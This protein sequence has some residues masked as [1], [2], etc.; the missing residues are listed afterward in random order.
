M[1]PNDFL[2]ENKHSPKTIEETILPKGIKKDF[3]KEI[4]EGKISNYLFES[5]RPGTGKTTSALAIA[6]DIGADVLFIN[7]SENG[8]I[9][10]L[11]NDIRGFASTVSLTQSPKVVI[12]DEFDNTTEAFQKAF[13][14]FIEEF[15]DNCRFIATCNYSN[16]ILEPVRDRFEVISFIFPEDEKVSLMKQ[17]IMRC[18]MILEKEG[19]EVTD[20]KIVAELV[21][22]NYPKLRTV[23]KLLQKYSRHGVIDEGILGKIKCDDAVDEL[24]L[25]LK[26]KNFKDVNSMIPRFSNDYANFIGTLYDKLYSL[27]TPSSIPTLIEIIGEN[28]CYANQVPDVQ[29]HLRFLCVMIIK[30]VGFKE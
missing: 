27:V 12:L 3:L 28:Q 26:A 23:I 19:I 6:N 24:I 17:A 4:K 15:S 30:E 25:A 8:N 20:K 29:I 18:L 22:Q 5:P 11:R 7:A 14:G 2:W 1:N 16:K 9:D 10:I 13:R 21:K